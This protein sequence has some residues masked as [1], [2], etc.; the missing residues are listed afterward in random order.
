MLTL[1]GTTLGAEGGK[2]LETDKVTAVMGPLREGQIEV[3]GVR[4]SAPHLGT[5]I[6]F[7]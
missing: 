6:G 3:D 1:I 4:Y 7:R 5:G 2:I